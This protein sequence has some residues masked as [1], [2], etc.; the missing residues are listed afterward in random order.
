MNEETF[1]DPWLVSFI[2]GLLYNYLHKLVDNAL[3]VPTASHLWYYAVLPVWI[4]H[5]LFLSTMTFH[6]FVLYGC[7]LCLL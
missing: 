3:Y 1:S 4:F 6:I 2:Q 7:M 5:Y